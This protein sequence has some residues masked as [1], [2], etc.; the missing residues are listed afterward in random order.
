MV[1]YSPADSTVGTKRLGLFA[2]DFLGKEINVCIE[3]L[4][5]KRAAILPPYSG[6]SD[7]YILLIEIKSYFS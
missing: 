6:M 5:V 3:K 2:G 7:N 4:S 1:S